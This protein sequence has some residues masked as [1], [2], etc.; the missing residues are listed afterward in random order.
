MTNKNVAEK[1]YGIKRVFSKL[2]LFLGSKTPFLT[3]KIRAR[4]AKWGGVVVM[5]PNNTLIG[6]E[7]AFD[8]LYPQDIMIGE[9]TIITSGV[10]ILTHFVSG[11]YRDFIFMEHGK[12]N[13][14]SK[15]FIGMNTVIV[16]SVTIGDGAIIGANSVV[17]CD[18]PPYTIWGG[19]PAKYI[20]DRGVK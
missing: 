11:E 18:I 13:I 15:V 12:V 4:F 17:T 19:N 1:T 8:D 20:K 16:K 14:G 10:K 9:N 6:Y 3:M 7:V 2:I 5:N